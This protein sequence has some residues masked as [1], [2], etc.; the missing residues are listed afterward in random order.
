MK[1]YITL[2]LVFVL[3]LSFVACKKTENPPESSGTPS[4]NADPYKYT[5]TAFV[6]DNNRVFYEIFVGSFADGDGDG[7]GDLK[8]VTNKLDYLNDG[9]D[10]THDDLGVTGIW[11][12]P[13]CPGTTYHKY[14]V[15][16]YYNIDGAYGTLDDF[17]ELARECRK[18]GIKLIVDLVLNHSSSK[19]PWFLKA[20]DAR[21]RNYES[22]YK[23]WYNF[24]DHKENDKYYQIDQNLWYEGD[25]WSEMPDFN[26]DSPSLREEVKAIVDFWFEK[27]AEGFRLDAAKHVYS[28]AE[29]NIEFWSWFNSYC[30]SKKKDAYTVAEVWS[31]GGEI[32][33]Y[34][35][36]GFTSV[37]NYEGGNTSGKIISV[38]N[39]GISY[40]SPDALSKWIVD[41]NNGIKAKNPDAIDAPFLTNHDN[42]RSFGA[43][44]R[45]TDN[46]KMAALLY[47]TMPGSPFI[48][49]GEEIGMLGS[50]ID[51][52]KRLGMLWRDRGNCKDPANANWAEQICDPVSVQLKDYGSLLHTYRMAIR[53]RAENPEIGRGKV[54]YYNT[55]HNDVAAWINEYNG[56]KVAVCHNLSFM[57]E[58]ITFTLN[59]AKLR[60]YVSVNGGKPSVKEG[61]V[62]I[63]G[64]C[65]AVFEIQ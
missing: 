18:R 25:F 53:L 10:D 41:F 50:G 59:G 31:P 2:V 28:S 44:R 5:D 64:Y 13:I 40:N 65:T 8:G 19:N 57:R 24:S 23:D 35:R 12:M 20:V 62:T 1:K 21:V 4:E 27:G 36:A 47:L 51:E 16:D 61:S 15:T 3:C 33:E 39:S 43:L 9:N 60:G 7:R 46:A 58:D 17:T 6:D 29:K 30:R 48:Y 45:N 55:G 49:Y 14:D 11:L 38:V 34:H 63:P 52:N 32:K 37:F 22:K 42:A 26:M 54:S 56:K